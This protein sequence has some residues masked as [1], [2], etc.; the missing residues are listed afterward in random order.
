MI[1]TFLKLFFFSYTAIKEKL[2]IRLQSDSYPFIKPN[3]LLIGKERE[4]VERLLN[5]AYN[6]Q[7]H[8]CDATNGGI[9]YFTKRSDLGLG[10][11]LNNLEI[12]QPP[13]T[14][15]IQCNSTLY[16]FNYLGRLEG[17][18][19][20]ITQKISVYEPYF[21]YL[22]D[23]FTA[24]TRVFVIGK[25]YPYPDKQSTKYNARV[26]GRDGNTIDDATTYLSISSNFDI[27]FDSSWGHSLVDNGEWERN[28]LKYQERFLHFSKDIIMFSKIKGEQIFT[29]IQDRKMTY[30]LNATSK[31]ILAIGYL[32]MLDRKFYEERVEIPENSWRPFVED[33]FTLKNIP[34]TLV[35]MSGLRNVLLKAIKTVKV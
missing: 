18:Y 33:F 26:Q 13:E 30:K 4:T 10:G 31:P 28:K 3:P 34:F 20:R 27:S 24:K 6:G 16:K 11:G 14:V 19:Y 22:T 25:F 5:E 35:P 21:F 15:Q 12:R 2:T 7:P 23:L 1:E 9:R 8:T 32:Y 29:T 17:E